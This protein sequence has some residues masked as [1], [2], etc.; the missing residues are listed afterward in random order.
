M[1]GHRLI[2]P[3]IITDDKD[4]SKEIRLRKKDYIE[5]KVSTNE[6]EKH[7]NQ[8]YEIKSRFKNGKSLLHKKKRIG[9]SFEDE[10]WVLFKDMGFTELNKGKLRIDVTPHDAKRK[11][12]KQIDV[13]AKAEK[14]VFVIECKAKEML[15]SKSLAKDIAEIKDLKNRIKRVIREHYEQN[16]LRITFVICTTNIDVSENDEADAKGADKI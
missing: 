1:C 15:G 10:V 9:D 12:T 5:M 7:L 11:K 16:D 14:D 13:F 4:F 2:H 8:G 3:L 6:E